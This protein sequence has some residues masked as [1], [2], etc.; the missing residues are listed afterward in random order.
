MAVESWPRHD[1]TWLNTWLKRICA[2]R[3]GGEKI[4]D[5]GALSI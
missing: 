2:R 3:N 5:I 1:E 4:G